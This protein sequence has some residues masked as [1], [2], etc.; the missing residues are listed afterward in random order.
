[1]QYETSDKNSVPIKVAF[2]V[3]LFLCLSGG[4]KETEPSMVLTV[5]EIRYRKQ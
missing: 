4:R 3:P 5:V 1:M 2:N